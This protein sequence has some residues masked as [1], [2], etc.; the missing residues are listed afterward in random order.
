MFLSS[1]LALA[2]LAESP[3][4]AS[5]SLELLAAPVALPGDTIDI[6]WTSTG[7]HSQVYVSAFSDWGQQYY[8]DE[9]TANDGAHSWTLPPDLD[10]RSEVHL[11][12]E[13]AEAGARTTECW[14]YQAVDVAHAVDFGFAMDSL[15]DV[16]QNRTAYDDAIA[17]VTQSG[18]TADNGL[19]SVTINQI[20]STGWAS[21][22]GLLPTSTVAPHLADL[23]RD[24]NLM[25][26]LA[27]IP[28]SPA[29][30]GCTALP[31]GLPG[32]IYTESSLDLLRSQRSGAHQYRV[33]FP[34][35]FDSTMCPDAFDSG[36]YSD[37]VEEV[38]A[39]IDAS[40]PVG[41]VSWE[42]G[43][44][45]DGVYFF[46]GAAGAY[47]D[48]ASAAELGIRRVDPTS[49]ITYGGFGAS[50]VLD[51]GKVGVSTG[52]DWDDFRDT[53]ADT[54]DESL[55]F[56]LFRNPGYGPYNGGTFE[57][58][59][60]DLASAPWPVTDAD[61]VVLS[62]F[63]LFGR[64]GTDT[65]KAALENSSWLTYE[66]AELLFFAHERDIDAIYLW[67]LLDID[68]E[69]QSGFFDECGV[70]RRSYDLLVDVWE[71]VEDGYVATR[72][73]QGL[74]EIRGLNG[75]VLEA[76]ADQAIA[77]TSDMDIQSCWVDDLTESLP[78][79]AVGGELTTTWGSMDWVI[80]AEVS[81]GAG[82]A[83][84]SVV[85]VPTPTT[86]Q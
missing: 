20:A 52:N 21:G 83:C 76:S 32:D 58:S 81:P 56:H 2:L 16:T 73:A 37:W 9:I 65:W 12:I 46:W 30:A 79:G 77:H 49:R 4:Q 28:F 38:A 7:S 34:P 54:P 19:P 8:L 62:A 63:D 17:E 82:Q 60:E 75:L 3:A 57:K 69:G 22:S 55:S 27:D 39:D 24:T 84:P 42:T 40:N 5:C 51:M 1:L 67:K 6:E 43:N 80:Y 33:G 74:V 15:A 36:A 48:K 70:P 59:W 18:P 45:P 13:S 64:N 61:H 10:H 66:L 47:Q 71:V 72:D 50:T 31:G 26:G 53:L 44:E 25:V 68:S 29:D 14:Q 35:V 23:L 41:D 85:P 78:S 86:C 11:Y